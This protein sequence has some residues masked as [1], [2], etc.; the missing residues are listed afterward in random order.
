MIREFPSVRLVECPT[1]TPNAKVGVLMDLARPRR[2]TILIVNDAD[3]RVERGLSERVTA[4]LAD[5][6]VGLVTCLYRAD[7]DTSRRDLKAW[8]SRPISRRRRWSRAW[9]ASTNSRMGS[10]M[11]FRRADLDRIGGFA[12]IADYLADDY[13]LGHRIHVWD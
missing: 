4:P 10:T 9:S 3:I 7:G 12:A 13:Q 11:A 1:R 6:Q 8:A 5:P 2:D